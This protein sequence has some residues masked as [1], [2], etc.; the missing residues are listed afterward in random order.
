VRVI[1]YVYRRLCSVRDS[2]V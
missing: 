1:L 2:C